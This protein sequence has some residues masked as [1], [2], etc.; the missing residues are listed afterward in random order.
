MAQGKARFSG[1]GIAASV[2]AW[3]CCA[4]DADE[5]VALQCLRKLSYQLYMF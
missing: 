4:A 3:D 1:L 5:A 2:C